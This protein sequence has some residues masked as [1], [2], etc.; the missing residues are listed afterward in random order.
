MGLEL[1][2]TKLMNV[3]YLRLE[4]SCISSVGSNY[5]GTGCLEA[6]CV[7]AYSP[8]LDDFLSSSVEGL[9]F[10]LSDSSS[11]VLVS[12]GSSICSYSYAEDGRAEG[13]GISSCF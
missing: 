4:S 3:V 11:L 2:E 9:I 7:G 5:G 12:S 1:L 13:A 8:P 6:Y 10:S